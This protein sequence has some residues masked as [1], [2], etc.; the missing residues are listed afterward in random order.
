MMEKILLAAAAVASVVLAARA[1]WAFVNP[2][3][4]SE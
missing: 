4:D 1:A 3:A 2:W